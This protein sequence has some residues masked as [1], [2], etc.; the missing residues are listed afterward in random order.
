MLGVVVVVITLVYNKMIWKMNGERVIVLV[1][2]ILIVGVSQFQTAFEIRSG[3]FRCDQLVKPTQTTRLRLWLFFLSLSD[4]LETSPP[5]HIASSNNNKCHRLPRSDNHHWFGPRPLCHAN[6]AK[7]TSCRSSEDRSRVRETITTS[8][9]PPENDQPHT[10]ATQYRLGIWSS[11]NNFI[12]SARSCSRAGP[13]RQRFSAA[14]AFYGARVQTA[15]ADCNSPRSHASSLVIQY[16][17]RLSRP[18]LHLITIAFFIAEVWR[19]SLSIVLAD[20]DSTCPKYMA[21]QASPPS[22]SRAPLGSSRGH[23]SITS[24]LR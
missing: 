16:T 22:L 4:F 2:R 3:F 15:C 5:F 19:T 11:S 24:P 6:V 10:T 21:H 18:S 12:S 14:F 1:S 17:G 13:Q 9:V 8:T 20:V 7:S 23:R